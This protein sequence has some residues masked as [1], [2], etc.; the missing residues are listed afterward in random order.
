MEDK[1]KCHNCFA[2]FRVVAFSA[3]PPSTF[4]SSLIVSSL[5]NKITSP[6][7]NL[8]L[9]YTVLNTTLP[10][11]TSSVPD[12]DANPNRD[13][14]DPHVFPAP[15]PDSFVRGMDPDPDLDPDPY[16]ILLSS[17]ENSMKTLVPAVLRLPLDSGSG[18]LFHPS[19]IKQK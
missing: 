10:I 3:R 13:P 11:L 8:Y 9:K 4:R 18:S 6:P 12:P 5:C 14:P 15:N 19:I 1:Y 16:F 7:L 17:S 2:Y